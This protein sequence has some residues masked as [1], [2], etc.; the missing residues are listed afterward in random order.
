MEKKELS[1]KEKYHPNRI[2]VYNELV[3][4][5]KELNRLLIQLSKALRGS[6]PTKTLNPT[7]N[8]PAS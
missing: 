1:W 2:L 4:E 8:R 7:G 5:W 3:K 6:S